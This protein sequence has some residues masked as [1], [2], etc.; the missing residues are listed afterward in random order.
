MPTIAPR[1]KSKKLEE[2]DYNIDTFRSEDVD[3]ALDKA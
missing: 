3:K 2:N 1:N